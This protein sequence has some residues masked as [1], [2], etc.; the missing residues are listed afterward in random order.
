MR[1]CVCVPVRVCARFVVLM[2]R[3]CGM[4]QRPQHTMKAMTTTMTM[5]AATFR[6]VT[7]TSRVSIEQQEMRYE[8]TGKTRRCRP[9][10]QCGEGRWQ[11]CHE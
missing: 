4:Q 1:V 2:L 10:M 7:H 8:T 5:T 6:D 11:H 9:G 3:N